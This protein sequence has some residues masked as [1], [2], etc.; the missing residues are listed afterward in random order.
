MKK[1]DLMFVCK[2]EEEGFYSIEQRITLLDK[3]RDLVRA[4]FIR[5]MRGF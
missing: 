3:A 4:L 2:E 1:Q 5:L